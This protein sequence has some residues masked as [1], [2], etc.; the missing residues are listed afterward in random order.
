MN[1]DEIILATRLEADEVIE[2]LYNLL[3]TN[4]AASVADLYELVGA[5]AKYTDNKWG[6][7][8]LQESKPT[9][10]Q[11]GWLLVLPKPKPLD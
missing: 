6:W 2:R 10:V 7:T 8:D 9:R 11:S 4:K 3:S 1:F 5:T